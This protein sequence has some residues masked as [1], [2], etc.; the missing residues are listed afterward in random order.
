MRP[1]A[2]LHHPSGRD[3]FDDGRVLPTS[4]TVWNWGDRAVCGHQRRHQQLLLHSKLADEHQ[5]DG[6]T[7]FHGQRNIPDVA[8][9]ADNVYVIYDGDGS[10]DDLGGTSCAAPLWAGFMALVNQQA[11]SGQRPPDSSIPPF[12]RS[13][14]A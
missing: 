2:S 6:Q 11:A 5:H 12:M 9:T 8:L 14:K 3:N 13:A 10:S 1:P 7:G 4:E